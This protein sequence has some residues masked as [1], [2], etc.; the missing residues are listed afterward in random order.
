[1]AA[2][3]N[4]PRPFGSGRTIRPPAPTNDLCRLENALDHPLSRRAPQGEPSGNSAPPPGGHAELDLL[5]LHSVLYTG[6]TAAR[7]RCAKTE[8]LMSKPTQDTS[9][10]DGGYAILFQELYFLLRGISLVDCL[11]SAVLQKCSTCAPSARDYSSTFCTQ[12][13]HCLS[14]D[15]H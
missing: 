5:T 9:L 13:M 14:A 8:T 3:T 2:G 15:L 11:R 1:M 7:S 6:G 4:G 10:S 12:V